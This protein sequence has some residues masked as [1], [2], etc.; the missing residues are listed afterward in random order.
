MWTLNNENTSK[1][2]YSRVY[3]K[4]D[5]SELQLAVPHDKGCE[6]VFN[7]IS[8]ES[9]ELQHFINIRTEEF[10]II[11]VLIMYPKACKVCN[12]MRH[13]LFHVHMKPWGRL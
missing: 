9:L 1:E 10:D 3:W 12:W 5:P 6:G 8:C 13:S 7:S 11:L 4:I 2:S